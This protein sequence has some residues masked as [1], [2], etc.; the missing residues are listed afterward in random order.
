MQ[1]YLSGKALPKSLQN[2]QPTFGLT[3][4]RAV[5]AFFDLKNLYDRVYKLGDFKDL[6][7][8]LSRTMSHLRAAQLPKIYVN[9]PSRAFQ[10]RVCY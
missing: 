5:N 8:D 10:K 2:L 6:S 4:N 1:T 9:Q 3:S 7:Q